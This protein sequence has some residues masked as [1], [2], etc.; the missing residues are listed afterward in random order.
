ML[1]AILPTAVAMPESNEKATNRPTHLSPET[2][3][4]FES[5]DEAL[6]DFDEIQEELNYRQA[7]SSLR[8]MIA[9]LDLTD[10]ERNGLEGAIAGLEAMLRKLEES[11][12]HIAA[13]GMV[14][15]GKSSLL[16]ALLGQPVFEAG[17]IHGVTRTY[18]VANWEVT[19]QAFRDADHPIL[20][21][22]LPSAEKS[23][24][25]LIDTPGIDEVGGEA[26]ELL[27]KEVAEQSD[28][29]LFI[30]SGDITKVEYQAL[31]QLR[32]IGKPV[33]LV[34]NK[35]DQYPTAD[36]ESVFL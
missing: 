33:I 17:A 7:Q 20:K 9:K 30:V 8:E 15:R 26:R 6:M 2:F 3:A 32:D 27:A 21:V 23:T 36:R 25:Q 18:Q 5:F 22:A 4:L 11:V 34:F 31:S 13:F 14:G 35:V 28:L 1:K 19:K 16:N 12:V 24:I 29:L 10:R